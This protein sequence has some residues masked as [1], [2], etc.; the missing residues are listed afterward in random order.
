MDV[1]REG[2][3][4]KEYNLDAVTMEEVVR[5]IAELSAV[6]H[7]PAV[8]PLDRFSR[9]LFQKLVSIVERGGITPA[10]FHA[11]CNAN[12]RFKI[13]CDQSRMWDAI[14]LIK[15]VIK[16]NVPV[17]SIVFAD[18]EDN[19]LFQE[20]R[21][22]HLRMPDQFVRLVAWIA[23][24]RISVRDDD[25][26][27]DDEGEEQIGEFLR[28]GVDGAEVYRATGFMLKWGS[29]W[30]NDRGSLRATKAFCYPVDYM[31][32]G[33]FARVEQ[34][35][36]EELEQQWEEDNAVDPDDS[37]ADE[38]E[39]R[40]KRKE[41]S[42]GDQLTERLYDE[43][44]SPNDKVH[45]DDWLEL[46]SEQRAFLQNHDYTLRNGSVVPL[47]PQVALYD[48]LIIYQLLQARFAP[49][50]YLAVLHDPTAFAQCLICAN[51]SDTR[52]KG[53]KQ[54]ICGKAC[55]TQHLQSSICGK[56]Q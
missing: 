54:L 36:R 55:Q 31:S 52:C 11:I 22:E 46:G 43:S 4:A 17:A 13:L 10:K 3:R 37:Y 26:D 2:K 53:C 16:E 27:D 15:F 30:H 32:T 8:F 7:T 28:K 18:Y 35:L 51:V 23:A 41:D 40:E 14:F 19:P 42:V 48:K 45:H 33:E 34:E 25:D 39:E 49:D 47:N 12:R 38:E 6:S 21:G 5:E 56:P 9:D 24:N 20:W 1:E 50:E 44:G 29:P